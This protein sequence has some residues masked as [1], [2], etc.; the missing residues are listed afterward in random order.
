MQHSSGGSIS[1]SLQL[2][3]PGTALLPEVKSDHWLPLG[4]FGR[5]NLPLGSVFEA[6]NVTQVCFVI[7]INF[8]CKGL[9]CR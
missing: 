1:D 8:A 2:R 4:V 7:F 3:P 5:I 9:I 6:D